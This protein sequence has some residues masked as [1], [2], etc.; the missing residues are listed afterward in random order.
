LAPEYNLNIQAH[1]PTALCA[2]HNFIY[3]HDPIDKPPKPDNASGSC[4]DNYDTTNSEQD[5]AAATMMEL[6]EESDASRRHDYIAQM[7]WVE[8]QCICAE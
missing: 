5:E 3:E 4:S 1:I 7:M 8:Y 2:I 6:E